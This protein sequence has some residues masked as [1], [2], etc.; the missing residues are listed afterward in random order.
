MSKG[1]ASQGEGT[2]TLKDIL[3]GETGIEEAVGAAELLRKALSRSKNPDRDLRVVILRLEGYKAKEV[4]DWAG[5]SPANVD[6]IYKRFHERASEIL[7]E[8]QRKSEDGKAP[9]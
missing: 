9:G 7:D 2:L 6:Q 1:K 8:D 3:V 4:A 5:I